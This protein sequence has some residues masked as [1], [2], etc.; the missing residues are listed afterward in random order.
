MVQMKQCYAVMLHCSPCCPPPNFCFETTSAA[1]VP[2][3][4]LIPL[5][6]AVGQGC[7]A[8][9]LSTYLLEMYRRGGKMVPELRGFVATMTCYKMVPSCMLH[10]ACNNSVFLLM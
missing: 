6:S 3:E 7:L 9:S 2:M 5:A 8:N 10:V 1:P 4:T